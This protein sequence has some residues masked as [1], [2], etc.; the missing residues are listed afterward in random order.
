M[1]DACRKKNLDFSSC[2]CNLGDCKSVVYSTPTSSTFGVKKVRKHKTF[3]HL[4][5]W[6]HPL[7]RS[8]VGA[9]RSHTKLRFQQ[10][11]QAVKM[12]FKVT[13][14]TF[15]ALFSLCNFELLL[16]IW[17]RRLNLLSK[18]AIKLSDFA[19]WKFGINWTSVR[20]KDLI[21]SQNNLRFGHSLL[22]PARPIHPHF[23]SQKLCIL[24]GL[25]TRHGLTLGSIGT[26]IY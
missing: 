20:A 5:Q 12:K 1:H 15:C 8:W 13:S 24:G 2:S 17:T 26:F 7:H 4:N 21:C 10:P 19:H 14:C 3:L 16:R 6:A 22:K 25:F 23:E 18:Q 11:D 9:K